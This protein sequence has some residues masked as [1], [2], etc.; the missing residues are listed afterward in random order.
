[1]RKVV[2]EEIQNPYQKG[3]AEVSVSEVHSGQVESGEVS[4][5][6]EEVSLE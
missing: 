3:K 1:M 6:T 5:G 2:K 4:D